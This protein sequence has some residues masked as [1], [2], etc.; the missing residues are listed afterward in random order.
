MEKELLGMAEQWKKT[1]LEELAKCEPGSR[2]EFANQMLLACAEM[3]EF[4]PKT[5]SGN[6]LAPDTRVVGNRDVRGCDLEHLEY[7][8]R[9]CNR[10]G[11]APAR[12]Q[13]FA[14]RFRKN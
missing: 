4:K 5:S 9:Y 8:F 10:S 3:L 12:L 1:A 13:S 2:S 11:P 6:R 14:R 7:A